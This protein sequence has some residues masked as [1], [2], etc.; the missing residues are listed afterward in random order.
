MPEVKRRPLKPLDTAIT[1]FMVLVW[2]CNAG[3]IT[4]SVFVFLN[5]RAIDWIVGSVDWSIVLLVFSAIG[6]LYVLIAGCCIL[7]FRQHI[8]RS[9][10]SL[11]RS[12]LCRIL[13]LALVPVLVLTLFVSLSVLALSDTSASTDYMRQQSDRIYSNAIS[14]NS[15]DGSGGGGGSSGN[16]KVLTRSLFEAYFG[17]VDQFK[18]RLVDFKFM[19]R[20][21]NLFDSLS[22]GKEYLTRDDLYKG[23]L[24]SLEPLRRDFGISMTFCSIIAFFFF[25]SYIIWYSHLRTEKFE[26]KLR[27][28]RTQASL[29]EK[30]NLAGR[31]YD[32]DEGYDFGENDPDSDYYEDE[33]DMERGGTQMSIR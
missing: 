17:R 11:R 28:L 16:E 4:C 6:L 7:G 14:I 29:H 13:N 22:G 20:L 24:I 33:Q 15:D 23:V 8:E 1:F 2:L 3:L 30:Q 19:R 32:N 12:S 26:D 18:N 5:W 27:I 21:Q 31:G 9:Y 10:I 25:L